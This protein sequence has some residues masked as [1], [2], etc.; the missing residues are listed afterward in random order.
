M[1]SPINL[2][3]T[4]LGKKQITS[5]TG[6]VLISVSTVFLATNFLILGGPSVF[7]QYWNI[8]T[9]HSLVFSFI[10][11]V[12][13]ILSILHLFLAIQITQRNSKARGRHYRVYKIRGRRSRAEG[14]MPYTSSIVFALVSW[15]AVNLIV[16][17]T[18][19]LKDLFL[20]DYSSDLYKILYASFSEPLYSTIYIITMIALGFQLSQSL[21][22]FVQSFGFIGPKFSPRFERF[23]T[24]LGTV[25]ALTYSFVPLYILFSH[26]YS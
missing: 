1:K 17:Q 23:S 12:I 22:N 10:G 5:L 11:A 14:L 13:F 19:P 15:Q 25:V 6:L 2:V 3:R 4:S 8:L 16:F 26:L 21:Q 7:Q 20:Q 9:R 18:P 24:D